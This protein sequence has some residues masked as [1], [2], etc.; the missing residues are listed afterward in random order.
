MPQPTQSMVHQNQPLTNLSVAFMQQTGQV[1]GSIFPRV[2][3]G[4]KSDTFYTYD[5]SYWL[6][7][8][9]QERAPGT[10][11]AGSGYPIGTDS[12]NCVRFAIHKD[13]PDPIRANADSPIM[14]DSEAVAYVSS[15]LILKQEVDW[16]SNFFGTSIWTGSSS[17]SDITPGV[18]WSD[19]A[20]D[21]I[22]D[23]KTQKRA[24]NQNTGLVPNVLVC[25]AKL[26]DDLSDHPDIIDRLKYTGTMG[27]PARASEQQL[28]QLFGLER[29]V[30]ARVIRNTSAEGV[31]ASYSFI[32]GT[33]NALLAYAAPNPGLMTPTAGYTFVWPENG[34]GNEFG[35]SVKRF[36]LPEAV[37]SDRVEAEM[38]Y[39]QKVISSAL[40]VFFSNAV[41][42]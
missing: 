7:S 2:I 29:V 23:I 36:R 10:E 32:A 16:V 1:A 33:R 22:G 28:A 21:P 9:A 19:A 39:D 11:S 34:S 30:V 12:Y 13:I 3:V 35:V 8:D 38:Y 41:A 31:A 14:L 5:R 27:S 37:E 26:F 20:S 17:G 6:R 40:G 42:A 4:K 15:Q 18:L 25:G 24:V